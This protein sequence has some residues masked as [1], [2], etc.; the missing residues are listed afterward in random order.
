LR[1][2]AAT[3]RYTYSILPALFACRNEVDKFLTV[4]YNTLHFVNHV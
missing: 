2:R 4:I 3:L 1:E